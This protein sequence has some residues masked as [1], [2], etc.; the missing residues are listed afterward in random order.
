MGSLPHLR[1]QDPNQGVRG[2]SGAKLPTV[3]PQM[4]NRSPG[5]H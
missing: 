4:Q 1:Q 3:L 5:R 2:Y